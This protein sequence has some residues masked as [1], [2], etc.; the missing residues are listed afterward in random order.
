MIQ[1]NVNVV[2]LAGTDLIRSTGPYRIATELRSA[3]YTCQVIDYIMDFNFID[4]IKAFK[5]AIGPDTK[6]LGVSSTFLYEGIKYWQDAKD[7]EKYGDTRFPVT[8]TSQIQKI[9]DIAKLI[10]PS[11]RIVIGGA[12]AYWHTYPNVDAIFTGYSDLSFIE[13]LKYIDGKNPFFR[14]STNEQGIMKVDESLIPK[15]FDFQNS[16]TVYH[17]SD[18]VRSGEALAIEISRGCIFKCKFCAYP[19]GGKKKN[20][21][22]KFSNTLR[23]EFIRNYNEHGTT[24]Y[25]YTDDTHNESV[26]KLQMMVDIVQSLPFKLEYWAYIRLDLIHAYPEQYQLLKDGGLASAYFGIETLNYESAKAIG[27]GLHPD[28]VLNELE[29]FADRMPDVFTSAS[30][31]CGL[32][33]ETKE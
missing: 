17:E 21:Y 27:K 9:I 7:L 1:S 6:V 20:D 14:F 8:L 11:I 28:K 12:Q 22:I 13:Y 31:I 2:M 25:L 32:P 16:Y 15:K 5:K 23:E 18:G 4:T 29:I 26:E 3:G 30:V 24:K 10:S 33:F 19:M